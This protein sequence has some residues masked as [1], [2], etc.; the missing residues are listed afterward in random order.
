MD[1]VNIT[2]EEQKNLK[3]IVNEITFKLSQLQNPSE[4]TL[5]CPIPFGMTKIYNKSG[6]LREQVKKS[7]NINE[8]TILR[9]LLF[10]KKHKI[11]EVIYTKNKKNKSHEKKDTSKTYYAIKLGI[12]GI[13]DMIVTDWNECKHLIKYDSVYKKFHSIEECEEYFNTVDVNKMQ[14][15]MIK[16]YELHQKKKK[17]NAEYTKTEIWIKNNLIASL[18]ELSSKEDVNLAKIINN[19]IE[20]YLL[21]Y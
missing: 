15:Y 13:Q 21:K 1:K 14:E 8:L 16:Q 11:V 5:N 2:I 3:K 12:D 18:K 17:L 4:I 9:N 19:A 7:N 10:D 20:E 6:N